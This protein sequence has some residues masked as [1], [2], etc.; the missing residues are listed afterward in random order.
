MSR[1]SVMPGTPAARMCR[2]GSRSV[3][4]VDLLEFQ[5]FRLR[6]FAGSLRFGRFELPLCPRHESG[7]DTHASTG[8]NRALRFTALIRDRRRPI[9]IS[10]TRYVD[11]FA[12]RNPDQ[13]HGAA[14][15]GA[16]ARHSAAIVGRGGAAEGRVRAA[17]DRSC[18]EDRC[19]G[20]LDLDAE[21]C[22]GRL[23]RRSASGRASCE[24]GRVDRCEDG[25]L[26][27]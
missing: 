7:L 12:C 23:R 8:R 20:D 6:I 16:P 15:H 27:E 17:S 5:M 24:D 1:Q 25:R 18:C 2:A 13:R 11:E 19:V 4:W 21:R 26:V 10:S 22:I 9:R 14:R 3:V